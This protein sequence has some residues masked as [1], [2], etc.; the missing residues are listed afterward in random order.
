VWIRNTSR[1]P[2]GRVQELVRFGTRE[3]DMRKVCV[4]VK[5]GLLGGGAYNGVPDLSNAPARAKFLITLRLGRRD[6]R[7]PLG[8]VNYHFH[9]PE[10]TGPRNRFPFFVC[11]NWQEWLVKLAAHE[12]KHIEQFRDGLRCSELD[13]EH[14]AIRVLEEFRSA[15]QVA[16][17]RGAARLGAARAASS[18]PGQLSLPGLE[19]VSLVREDAA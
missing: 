10:E 11:R 4:N 12:A 5:N 6:Q 3:V 19:T 7:W 2:D 8:P 16:A 18:A 14:H 9:A 17:E 15:Q 13:C 1:Y